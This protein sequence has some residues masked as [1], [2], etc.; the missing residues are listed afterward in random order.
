MSGPDPV[1]TREPWNDLISGA[2]EQSVDGRQRGGWVREGS[3][4]SWLAR[5][6]SLVKPC[7]WPSLHT[8]KDPLFAFL[9]FALDRFCPH[10]PAG[11]ARS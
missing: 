7:H 1:G 2:L 5:T 9:F 8:Q 6:V 4:G 10:C 11:A 3:A